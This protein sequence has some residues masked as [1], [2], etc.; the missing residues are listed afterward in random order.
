MKILATGVI[1]MRRLYMDVTGH[2]I[3]ASVTMPSACMRFFRSLL[4][5]DH[6][7]I[8]PYYG[9]EKPGSQSKLG[10]QFLQVIYV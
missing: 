7:A 6:L 9:Y 4:Q 1:E 2:D 10:S 8:T 3:T 5:K